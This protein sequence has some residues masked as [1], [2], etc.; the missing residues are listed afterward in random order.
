MNFNVIHHEIFFYFFY[1]K[2]DQM[3]KQSSDTKFCNLNFFTNFKI[4]F[5]QKKVNEIAEISLTE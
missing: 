4:K 1:T 2:N 5:F 3:L